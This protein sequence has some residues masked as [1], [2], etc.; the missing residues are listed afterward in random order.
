MSK[1][2]TISTSALALAVLVAIIFWII[3]RED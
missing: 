1:K 3:G 2:V